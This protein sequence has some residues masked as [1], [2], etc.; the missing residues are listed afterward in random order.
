MIAITIQQTIPPSTNAFSA[1]P[2][3]IV[4]L[5]PHPPDELGYPCARSQEILLTR[6]LRH[7]SRQTS[8]GRYQRGRMG[9]DQDSDIF[10]MSGLCVDGADDVGEGVSYAVV[11]L[12]DRLARR[13]WDDRWGEGGVDVKGRKEIRGQEGEGSRGGMEEAFGEAVPFP[14]S[15]V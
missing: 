5:S 13:R 10:V 7:F 8:S 11:E 15:I 9:A 12:R 2:F 4:T 1:S 14:A 3:S 6:M